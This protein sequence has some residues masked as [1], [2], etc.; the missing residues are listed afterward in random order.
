M[1]SDIVKVLKDTIIYGLGRSAED[2]SKF[3][4][5]PLYTRFLTP[6]DYGIVSLVTLITS[7]SREIFSL[8]THSSIFRFHLNSKKDGHA[9]IF[10]SALLMIL[11]WC[12]FLFMIIYFISDYISTF[13]FDTNLYRVHLLIGFATAI[14]IC[15]YNI[16]MFI[17]RA[18]DNPF[19]FIRNNIVK[20]FLNAIIGILIIVFLNRK[21]IGV[22]E[23]NF[24][25]AF[26]FSIYVLYP[27]IKSTKFKLNLSTMK[28]ML[29]FGS[30]LV[31]AGL[32][33]VVLNSSDRYFLN[34]YNLLHDVGVY[35]IG[36]LIGNGIS[37]FINA[38]KT[39]WPQIMYNYMDKNDSE[40]FYGSIFNYYIFFMGIIWL[41]ISIFCKEILMIFTPYE[42]W[43]AYK[44]IPIVS[45]SYVI[46]GASSLTSVGIYI[47]DK[48]FY[49]FII[50]PIAAISCILLNHFFIINFGIFG[51]GLAT[52]F[53]FLI[54]FLLYSFFG[55]KYLSIE[56]KLKNIIYFIIFILFAY[57]ISTII[58]IKSF[59]ISIFFK[60]IIFLFSFFIISRSK[61]FLKKEFL[62]IKH[63][64]SSKYLKI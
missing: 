33:M 55:A 24:L 59:W 14:F 13:L 31:L 58:S 60:I 23:T 61:I 1:K 5:L 4:L 50:T 48:T 3:L 20:I 12:S 42:Y 15:I 22:L 38:F 57:I 43:G 18:N 36:Y 16:P 30:P 52:F 49:D 51:A 27:K 34:Q 64:F 46:Y 6:A 40:I 39:A 44:I 47:K 32:G 25:T 11:I 63:Y 17:L 8:G 19:Q 35:S 9:E 21:S 45:M 7:V 10:Y 37:V 2:L 41:A 53:S 56:Y 26:L 62:F 29:T 54:L 28:D